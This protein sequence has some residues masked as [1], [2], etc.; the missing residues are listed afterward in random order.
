LPGR[1]QYKASVEKDLRRL[2][3]QAMARV[4]EGI[5]TK[6]ARELPV[7]IPLSGEFKGLFRLS[8]GDYRVIYSKDKD[9]V[10]VLRI[11]HRK[12]AYR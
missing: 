2:D 10:L 4:L 1:V 11:S 5:E 9:G 8:I 3:R 7:G 12:E 6:L